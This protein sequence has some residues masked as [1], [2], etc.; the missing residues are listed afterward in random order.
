MQRRTLY[1]V[2]VG[3]SLAGY[4]WLGWQSANHA[5]ESSF[6]FC[7]MKQ[8]SGIPCP[9][10]GTTRAMVHLAQGDLAQSLALNPIGMV[11]AGGLLLFPLWIAWDLSRKKES[12]YRWYM[13]FER[14]FTRSRWIS[15]VAICI[16]LLNW[17][18]NISKGL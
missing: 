12:F 9:S 1:I 10:C 3:L 6:S 13:E 17:I 16:V 18:W 2:V 14:M 8:V 11:L 7:I 5:R 4:A 15:L